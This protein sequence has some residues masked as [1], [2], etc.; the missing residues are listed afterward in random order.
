MTGTRVMSAA[1]GESRILPRSRRP[2]VLLRDLSGRLEACNRPGE[3]IRACLPRRSYARAI[4][5][6]LLRIARG[7]VGHPWEVRREAA[8][9][10]Q[11][12]LLFLAPAR[13]EEHDFWLVQLGLKRR[14]G[15]DLLL[16]R[17]VLRE[18]FLARDVRGF[19]REWRRRLM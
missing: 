3:L 19:V 18:G 5:L 10:L 4:G 2:S 9:M 13:L 11:R 16:H 1:L 17:E 6:C 7:R 14:K 15:I 8:L 12:Q